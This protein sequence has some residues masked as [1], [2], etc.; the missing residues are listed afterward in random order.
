[1]QS[2]PVGVGAKQETDGAEV[3]RG[4]LRPHGVEEP[5]V[6]DRTT[7][8]QI[9]AVTIPGREV[10]GWYPD[11]D[12]AG[13]MRY[14]DGTIWSAPAVPGSHEGR[15]H[16]C[17]GRCLTARP[18][19]AASAP[20]QQLALGVVLGPRPVAHLGPKPLSPVSRGWRA[21]NRRRSPVRRKAATFPSRCSDATPGPGS[22]SPATRQWGGHR[23]TNR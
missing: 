21:R 16:R 18:F 9:S 5:G 13:L 17:H 3:E 6:T 12:I 2:R 4:A 23:M 15:Y 19:K 7:G 1:M 22:V 14:Q 11:P 8:P 20:R 10:P